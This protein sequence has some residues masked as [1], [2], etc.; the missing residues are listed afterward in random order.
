M[1]LWVF[2]PP[3]TVTNVKTT[4]TTPPHTDM[5]AL[6]QFNSLLPVIAPVLL[7]LASASIITIISSL[8]RGDRAIL[9][10]VLFFGG[11]LAASIQYLRTSASKELNAF[12]TLASVIGDD[13]KVALTVVG[14]ALVYFGGSFYLTAGESRSA[15]GPVSDSSTPASCDVAISF[16][17]PSSLPDSDQ[18]LFEQTFDRFILFF[19]NHLFCIITLTP[20]T[21]ARDRR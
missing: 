1:T 18:E 19:P 4:A 9:V 6:D 20:Q 15:G 10:Q 8:F 17:V 7:V 5:T 3:H 21:Q 11:A 2:R 14:V 12:L 16:D 13:I